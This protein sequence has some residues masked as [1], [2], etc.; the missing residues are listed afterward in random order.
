MP[1]KRPLITATAS[2]PSLYP[3]VTCSLVKTRRKRTS[4]LVQAL[5]LHIEAEEGIEGFGSIK[6][7]LEQ[8][9]HAEFSERASSE[10][11]NEREGEASTIGT[12]REARPYPRN[13]P[14]RRQRSSSHKRRSLHFQPPSWWSRPSLESRLEVRPSLASLRMVLVAR[15][16]RPYQRRRTVEHGPV[17]FFLASPVPHAWK[18]VLDPLNSRVRYKVRFEGKI[19]KTYTVEPI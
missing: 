8:E 17:H 7:S 4:L 3:S 1:S 16:C 12:Y 5:S 15:L 9:I 2:P 11:T 10:T 6:A 18:N 14:P 19:I 13:S